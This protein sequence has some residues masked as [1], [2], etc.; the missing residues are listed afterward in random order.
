MKNKKAL[1]CIDKYFKK[2][3]KRRGQAIAVY[4]EGFIN[5]KFE[6]RIKE[7]IK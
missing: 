1:M 3:D 7:K 2:G 4:C 6:A 5:G